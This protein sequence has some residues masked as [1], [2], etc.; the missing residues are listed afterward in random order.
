M[1][2]GQLAATFLPTFT[3]GVGHRTNASA[4][5]LQ[6]YTPPVARAA[7]RALRVDYEAFDLPR[8]AWAADIL[9]QTSC[10]KR[11]LA[12]GDSTSSQC[13]DVREKS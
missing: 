9:S 10:A 13:D 2:L 12:A 4:K 1:G 7:L 11:R 3:A 5:L 8:P 6:F